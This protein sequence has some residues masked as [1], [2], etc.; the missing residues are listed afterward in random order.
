M[1]EPD[2]GP[3]DVKP[4]HLHAIFVD[5]S[6][7]RFQ[8]AERDGWPFHRLTL[9]QVAEIFLD[10]HFCL[11]RIEVADDGERCVVWCV[12][13]PEERLYVF[14]RCSTEISHGTD[15]RPRI[16]MSFRIHRSGKDFT[17]ATVGL[18]VVTLLTLV[19]DHVALRIELGEV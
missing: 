3:L 14:F 1:L 9:R 2:C 18:V 8:V 17:H 5:E 6:F 7:A 10:P 4:W 15:H 12:V 11:R 16:R 19:L 13:K